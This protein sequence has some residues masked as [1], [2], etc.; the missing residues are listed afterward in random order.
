MT[1]KDTQAGNRTHEQNQR[2]INK[3]EETSSSGV[4]SPG[5]TL[6]EA[7]A[8]SATPSTQYDN[9]TG[10]R[11]IR[12]GNTTADRHHKQRADDQA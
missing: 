2:I 4:P 9:S 3:Q 12:H 10:D 6:E 8:G 11:S 5:D 7:R 1:A